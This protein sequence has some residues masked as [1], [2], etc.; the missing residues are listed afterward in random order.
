MSIGMPIDRSTGKDASME[1]DITMVNHVGLL[2]SDINA[3]VAR[4]EHFGFQFAPLSRVR[5]AFEPGAEPEATG[6]GKQDAIFEQNFLEIAGIT[7][8]DMWDKLPQAQRGY[9]DI[10]G[11]LS[12]YQGLH[13]LY[14]GTNT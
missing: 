10:D 13:I 12:R 9:F 14:F 6:L 2:V 7:E 4:Y 3:A 5:I 1:N 8:K 11:A